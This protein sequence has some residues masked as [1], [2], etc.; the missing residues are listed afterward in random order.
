ME[1]RYIR[2]YYLKNVN[3]FQ[4]FKIFIYKKLFSLRKWEINIYYML[5][6]NQ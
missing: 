6:A 2:E 3:Y 1:N 4:Y 5:E